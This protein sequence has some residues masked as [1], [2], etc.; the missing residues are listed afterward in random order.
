MEGQE[1]KMINGAAA[2]CKRS[3]EQKRSTEMQAQPQATITRTSKTKASL[4]ESKPQA[5]MV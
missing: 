5:T 3:S 4:I 1:S 2:R